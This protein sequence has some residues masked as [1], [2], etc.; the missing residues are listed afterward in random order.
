MR[1]REL[2]F[3]I[4]IEAAYLLTVTV[5]PKMRGSH[6]AFTQG[7]GPPRLVRSLTFYAGGSRVRLAWDDGRRQTQDR[8]AVGKR[9]ASDRNAPLGV[10][11]EVHPHDHRGCRKAHKQ[12]R[13]VHH[14][15]SPCI[16]SV[17]RAGTP[18]ACACTRTSAERRFKR[19]ASSNHTGS[20]GAW[21]E[22]SPSPSFSISQACTS[23]SSGSVECVLTGGEARGLVG[24]RR[25]LIVS[26]SERC[27]P[28][29]AGPKAGRCSI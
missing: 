26:I 16:K 9:R 12:R 4:V 13:E 3:P 10:N 5:T 28:G 27:E 1:H 21:A 11:G 20:P 23:Q 18:T 24:E 29:L 15:T 14:S 2:S 17:A 7:E 22:A 6:R 8:R 19:R 25:K